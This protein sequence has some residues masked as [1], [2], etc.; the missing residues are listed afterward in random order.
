MTTRRP[1]IVGNWK[2]YGLTAALD[3]A[4][5]LAAALEARPAGAEV[6][7]CP[8]ATLLE[9]LA[10][11][12]C[13]GVVQLGGQDCAVDASGAH[14]GD[15]AAEMLADAGARWVIVGHSERR[16]DHGETSEI[17][18]AKAA[19]GFRAGLK[20]IVCVGETLAQRRAGEAEAVVADQLARSIPPQASADLCLAYEPV[21]AIGTGLTPTGEEIAAMHRTILTALEARGLAEA[22]VLYGGSVK[23]DNAR[24]IL[25]TDGVHGALVGGA[26]LKA[27]EFE[28]IIR[29]A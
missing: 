27:A 10:R 29:A 24:E 14:T 9:R 26:S 25:A 15:I 16:A 20:P 28:A 3:E 12:L 4:Q 19:A 22:R 17:V 8:P 6:A 11:L 18:A 2:M 5:A 23:S 7:I 13:D 1:L 21:W